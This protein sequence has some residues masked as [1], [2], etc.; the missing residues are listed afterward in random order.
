MFNK[1]LVDRFLK[2]QNISGF[3]KDVLVCFLDYIISQSKKGMFL[4]FDSHQDAREFYDY[5]F[6]FKE[7]LFLFYPTQDIY[8]AVP[9]FISEPDRFRREALLSLYNPKIK[10]VCIGTSESFRA[11]EIPR[12][13]E[14]SISR[15]VFETN[16]KVEM[17]YVSSFLARWGYERVNTTIQPGTYSKRG[18]VLD[19]FPPHLQNPIRVLFDFDMIETITLFDPSNQRSIKSLNRIAI[20]DINKTD[21]NAVD[22]I[23]LVDVFSSCFIAK[24]SNRNGTYDLIGD[25]QDDDNVVVKFKELV[26]NNTSFKEKFAEL[27][28]Y[29]KNKFSIYIYGENEN[30]S[31]FPKQELSCS[32]KKENLNEGFVLSENKEL[33]VS[34]RSFLNTKKSRTKWVSNHTERDKD[35]SFS[36]ISKM[37]KGDFIVHRSFGVGVF[38]GLRFQGS[39]NNTKELLEIEYENNSTVFVSIEKLN[40][41]HKFIGS[42]NNPK[43]NSLGSKRWGNE[44]K[45]TRKA[46]SLIASE[47][48]SLYSKKEN[49]RSFKYIKNN[50]L[51]GELKSSFPFLETQDQKKAIED[52]FSDMNT[53]KPMDRLICGDV[54]FGKTEVAIRAV[55]KAALSSKQSLF[56]CPTTVLADQHYIS[57]RDRL[58]KFGVRVAL[59]SRF[60]TLS[61]QKLILE[62]LKENRFDLII[63]THRALSKDV[64]FPNLEFLL[65]SFYETLKDVELFVKD[66]I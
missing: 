59:L 9:G 23:G 2:N 20:S 24:V 33:H 36:D 19:V 38:L 39:S 21:N 63:G 1:F 48:L 11:K 54:G 18:D 17:D 34:S 58:E 35:L 12:D 26:F 55:F 15:I 56:L 60:K 3:N 5:C 31:S 27:K 53:T 6:D 45:K 66:L 44:L 7:G 4:E 52:V 50:D 62:Q 43:I 13:T 49:K 8:E 16:Q 40:L 46:V 25:K 14:K 37:K 57:C 51:N 61:E 22:K 47:L 29:E 64:F 28:K 42:S 10:G 41:V 65:F 32:W 30:R